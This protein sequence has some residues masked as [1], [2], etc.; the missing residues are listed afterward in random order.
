MSYQEKYLKYKAKY[1]ALK[2]KIDKS[3]QSQ[4]KLDGGKLFKNNN[5]TK[6]T[7]FNKKSNNMLDIDN[8]TDT[9]TLSNILNDVKQYGGNSS[10]IKKS[11]NL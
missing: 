7:N 1:T 2:S 10:N 9:P 8:L 6:T 3:K 5:L 4:I 11:F